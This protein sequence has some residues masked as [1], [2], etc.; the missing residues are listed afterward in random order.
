MEFTIHADT[1]FSL[2]AVVNSHGWVQLP[3]FEPNGDGGFRYVARLD[4]G[5]VAPLQ[6][7]PVENGVRVQAE[8][9]LGAEAQAE[10][11]DQVAW[12]VGLEQDLSPFYE[13]VEGEPRLAHVVA[14]RH[15]RLLRSPTL[16]EDVVKTILTTN[17]TWAGTIRMTENVV[18][19]FGDPLQADGQETARAFPTPQ[20]LAQ[21]DEE[22]LR[23][24]TGLGYRAPYV[25]GLARAVAHGELDLEAL[26]TADL[27]TEALRRELLSIKGVGDYAAANLL[28]LLGR[29]DYIPIDS[30]ALRAVSQ[31]WHDGQSIGP[32]DVRAAFEAWGEWKGLA[33]WF[34]R[35]SDEA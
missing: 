18:A 5:R 22:T 35:W 4:G 7:T 13:L 20:R 28:L 10:V 23:R 11:A 27:P 16:F 3:S 8:D 34:W 2:P 26:K 33:Y 17:T 14:H 24:E 9:G 32:A 1:P 6:V 19:Q 29:H 15:G 31:E 25:L 30:I 12:M 21:S